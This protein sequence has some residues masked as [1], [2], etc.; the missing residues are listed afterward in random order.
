V[1]KSE[2]ASG[3]SA[4]PSV[5]EA[6]QVPPGSG[7][8]VIASDGLWDVCTPREAVEIAARVHSNENSKGADDIACA[9]LRHAQAQ[10][11][12]DDVTVLVLMPS[13]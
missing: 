2:E 1:L 13:Q 4:E 11:S 8:V 6:V 9:L 3:L 12:G 7:V 10:R 5:S